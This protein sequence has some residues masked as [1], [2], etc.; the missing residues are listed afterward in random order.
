MKRFTIFLALAAIFAAPAVSSAASTTE[1]VTESRTSAP[2]H[3]IVVRGEAEII[4]V[5][6]GS[7]GLLVEGTRTQLMDLTSFLKNDTLY[8]LQT[9]PSPKKQARPRVTINIDNLT[10]LDVKGETT[11]VAYGNINS[12]ILT[13][14]VDEGADVNLDVR[15]LKVKS[16]V[17]GCGTIHLSGTADIFLS[18]CVGCG[19]IDMHDL[20]VLDKKS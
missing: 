19:M 6:E 8:I 4:L 10:L 9:N 11:V 18:D 7:P 13:I 12:D 1:V 17:L 3:A 14:K 15:A 20:T 2:F 5:P 16:S